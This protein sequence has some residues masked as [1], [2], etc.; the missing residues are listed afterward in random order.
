MS[1]SPHLRRHLP[2]LKRLVKLP[3]RQ[4]KSFIKTADKSLVNSICE[5]CINILNGC[6]PLSSY[7]K[8]K[9]KRNK[10]NLRRLVLK[11]TALGKKRKIL[12]KGGFLS[13]ILSTAIPVIGS[14]IAGAV[15]RGRRR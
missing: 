8:A 13:A 2:L 15:N 9:F 14:L 7:Q 11:K 4:K 1:P 12:Q 5:C 6:I 3:D 10:L